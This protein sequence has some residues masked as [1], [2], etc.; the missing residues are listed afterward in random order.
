MAGRDNSSQG[1]EIYLEFTQ[2][3]RHFKCAAID[4]AS[5][6]EVSVF[7]PTSVNQKDL[8]RLAIRKLQRRLSNESE[9]PVPHVR[10]GKF[11]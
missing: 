2:I 3:G 8:E 1:G 7:G 9:A 10:S 11:V 5:G 6:V 4:A